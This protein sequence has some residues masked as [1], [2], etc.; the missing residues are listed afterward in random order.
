MPTHL[1]RDPAALR[2]SRMYTRKME[3]DQYGNSPLLAGLANTQ[4]SS[5]GYSRI[6]RRV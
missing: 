4:S 2:A 6:M 3:K 1:S 5:I